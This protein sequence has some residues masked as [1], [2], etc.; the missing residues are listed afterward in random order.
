ML[1][2]KSADIN[3]YL[4]NLQAIMFFYINRDSLIND[5]K[6]LI[7]W[8]TILKNKNKESFFDNF[9]ILFSK[10][11]EILI[12]CSQYKSENRNQSF[13]NII[14]N[15]E[16]ILKDKNLKQITSFPSI[17]Q[18]VF[19]FLGTLKFD[20]ENNYEQAAINIILSFILLSS[21]VLFKFEYQKI[22]SDF[23]VFFIFDY[24]KTNKNE[25]LKPELINNV[26]AK[27]RYDIN[28]CLNLAQN[29]I[30]EELLKFN[31]VNNE[32]N[33]FILV[34]NIKDKIVDQN[35]VD[36]S[37]SELQV[38]FANLFNWKEKAIEYSYFNDKKA[39]ENKIS[40]FK[41][42]EIILVKTINNINLK[43][44][45]SPKYLS[46]QELLEKYDYF[47][48]NYFLTINEIVKDN[49][50]YQT[51]EKDI[52]I[53]TFTFS[54]QNFLMLIT[55]FL[56]QKF[57]S[58]KIMRFFNEKALI[59]KLE[60]LSNL[61]NLPEQIELQ[62]N[63]LSN[64]NGV[65]NIE[66]QKRYYIYLQNL[67]KL[68]IRYLA[69]NSD[70]KFKVN[71]KPV[72]KKDFYQKIY[73]NFYYQIF[74]EQKIDFDIQRNDKLAKE[75]F[76]KK[77]KFVVQAIVKT[78]CYKKFDKS[79]NSVEELNFLLN[80]FFLGRRK[81]LNQN[82]Y[83]NYKKYNANIFQKF[84][85]KDLKDLFNQN[86][87]FFTKMGIFHVLNEKFNNSDLKEKQVF[88]EQNFEIIK[89]NH[90][91]ILYFKNNNLKIFIKN[92]EL[93]DSELF[94]PYKVIEFVNIFYNSKKIKFLKNTS[95]VISYQ[96]IKSCCFYIIKQNNTIKCIYQIK[97]IIAALKNLKLIEK[98]QH[99]NNFAIIE[100]RKNL[101]SEKVILEKEY[102]N[103]LN[104][105]KNR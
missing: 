56:T 66:R 46:N 18:K 98:K 60:S 36:F 58:Q 45:V 94:N 2:K 40:D 37:I 90:D 83:V 105:L 32:I 79:F 4:E 89:Q 62:K 11:R 39:V 3:Q 16:L 87:L 14:N 7:T 75:R 103:Y 104:L 10:I 43:I 68:T 20:C 74:Y 73:D 76:V 8:K 96:N 17:I 27:Y 52:F 44:K 57:D 25:N 41:D 34:N 48:K 92:L 31:N 86:S 22:I 85:E 67:T 35:D 50:K 100:L 93:Q 23:K 1:Y 78:E 15:L 42:N 30:D 70:F 63:K 69:K 55:E 38:L 29:I 71:F 64:L 97:Q 82:L 91:L 12:E 6:N 95:L 72:D 81:E 61:Q 65:Y 54:K 53:F 51:K 26:F 102:L 9:K 33:N 84:V 80:D 19:N 88:K 99:F 47:V 21:F 28:Y 59:L 49:P 77:I 101:L 24:I 5:E 13:K